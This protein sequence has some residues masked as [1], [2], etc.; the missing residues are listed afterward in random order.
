MGSENIPRNDGPF[1]TWLDNF[2]TV[3]A[4]NATT[5]GLTTG[6]VTTL[7]AY[8]TLFQNAYEASELGKVSAK[9]L[10]GD[11]DSKRTAAEAMARSYAKQFLANPNIPV[12]LK[13][14]LGLKV[15]PTPLGPV[16]MPTD[17]AVTSL[18]NGTNKLKWNRAGNPQTTSFVIEA[19]ST[20]TGPYTM[21]GT[22]TRAKFSVSGNLP[23]TVVYYRVSAQRGGVASDF[24]AP[25]VTYGGL[26]SE[27]IFLH[28]AA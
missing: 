8:V 9:S 11:K 13:G 28:K 10:V 7:T 17:L 18:S 15:A 1:L 3:T 4:A 21:I 14:E 12:L 27:T 16:S 5:L 6:Q 2:A 22:T 24:C 23:G 25:V 26:E 20:L 19:A